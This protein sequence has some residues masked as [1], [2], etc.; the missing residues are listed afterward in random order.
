MIFGVVAVPPTSEIVLWL[1]G[2]YIVETGLERV[3][4]G[5]EIGGLNGSREDG[6]PG[7]VLSSTMG[8]GGARSEEVDQ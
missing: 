2:L 6:D 1:L 3:G 5:R 8:R 4:S 7:G